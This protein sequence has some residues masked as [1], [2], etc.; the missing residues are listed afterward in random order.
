[1]NL[2][3]HDGSS[4]NNVF[5]FEHSA[6]DQW[7]TNKTHR[8]TRDYL[9]ALSLNHTLLWFVLNSKWQ[10]VNLSLVNQLDLRIETLPY[11]YLSHFICAMRISF[12]IDSFSCIECEVIHVG[13]DSCTWFM[14]YYEKHYRIYSFGSWTSHLFILFFSE[15]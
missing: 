9:R 2:I 7:I 14:D 6:Y 3:R 10:N 15:K 4:N 8:I 13:I 1:M 11:H 5:K 12:C